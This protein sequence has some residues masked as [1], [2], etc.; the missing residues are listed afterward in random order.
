VPPAGGRLLHTNHFLADP[1]AGEDLE[2]AEEPSTFERLAE[3]ER[4]GA[5]SSHTGPLCR[6]I[7]LDDPWPERRATLASVVIQPGRL[8]V[9]DG[10]PCEVELREVPLP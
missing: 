10:P 4:G 2:A 1:P 8:R 3:L 9:A 6:H 7:S 5:L